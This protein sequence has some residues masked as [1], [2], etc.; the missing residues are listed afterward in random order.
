MIL[1]YHQLKSPSGEPLNT[2][3]VNP[4]IIHPYFQE[5]KCRQDGMLITV[6]I[7]IFSSK[8]LIL[9]VLATLHG[10]EITAPRRCTYIQNP[11]TTN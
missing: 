8:M 3:S 10:G 4:R 6:L 5:S 1:K 9:S 2:F 11:C 7:L